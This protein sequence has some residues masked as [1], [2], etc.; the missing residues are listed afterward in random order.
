MKLEARGIVLLATVLAV[1]TLNRSPNAAAGSD[2]QTAT[3]PEQASVLNVKSFGA[4]AGSTNSYPGVTVTAGS[5]TLANV[6]KNDFAVGNGILIPHAG[7]AYAGRPG[8]EPTLVPDGTRIGSTTYCYRLAAADEDGG[9]SAAGNYGC[10]STGVATLSRADHNRLVVPEFGGGNNGYYVWRSRDGGVCSCLSK[11]L[12]GVTSW[13]DTGEPSNCTANQIIPAAPPASALADDFSAKVTALSPFTL[14]AAPLTS[15]SNATLVH[16]D[17]VPVQL[18]LN[19]VPTAGASVHAPGAT[20]YLA[21]PLVLP[22]VRRLVLYGDGIGATVFRLQP[23]LAHGARMLWTGPGVVTPFDEAFFSRGIEWDAN[24]A[25]EPPSVGWEFALEIVVARRV[26]IRQ[27]QFENF[28]GNGFIACGVG[29]LNNLAVCD[30]ENNVLKN[31]TTSLVSG[32]PIGGLGIAAQGTEDDLLNNTATG[33]GNLVPFFT[34]HYPV[35]KPAQVNISGNRI[36]GFRV[37]RGNG[38]GG[39]GVGGLYN[40]AGPGNHLHPAVVYGNVSNNTIDCSDSGGA[41]SG[42]L[43]SGEETQNFPDF[44]KMP[45]A[46]ADNTIEG[47]TSEGLTWG[48]YGIQLCRVYGPTI[49]GGTITGRWPADTS[50]TYGVWCYHCLDST[51]RPSRIRGVRYGIDATV[52]EGKVAIDPAVKFESNEIDANPATLFKPAR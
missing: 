10:T 48:S 43:I 7:A 19:A 27:S 22:N 51:I 11:I 32:S 6:P 4:I 9:M 40:D 38:A 42:I 44:A 34:E 50:K 13:N 31:I 15:V 20:Y 45:L 18:A 12:P 41:C 39:I 24:S 52:T 2:V 49:S 16:D 3:T 37:P 29:A 35:G 23:R 8:P 26:E 5:K 21:R 46:V 1:L 14:S 28:T 36:Y 17:S 47:I 25:N 33:W 30:F